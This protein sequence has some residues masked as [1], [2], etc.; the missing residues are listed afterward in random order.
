MEEPHPQLRRYW[1]DD[2][3]T[4]AY[5]MTPANLV[6]NRACSEEGDGIGDR[7][8]RALL[9]VHGMVMNGGPNHAA[10]VCNPAEIA[11]AARGA[12]YFGLDTLGTLILELPAASSDSSNENA[13][14]RLSNDY[15]RLVPSDSTLADAF[16][17]RLAEAPQDFDPLDA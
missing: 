17:E 13:E 12:H 4:D 6:W 8:L 3:V 2:S 1:H 14:D 15:H 7:H 11:A 10:D 5:A 9:R 16:E